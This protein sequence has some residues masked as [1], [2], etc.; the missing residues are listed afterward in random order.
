M[1]KPHLCECMHENEGQIQKHYG[2]ESE[3]K[4]YVGCCEPHESV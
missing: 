3:R 1:Y 4:R 2:C